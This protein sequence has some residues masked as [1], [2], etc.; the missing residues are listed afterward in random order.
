[1]FTRVI[2]QRLI[3]ELAALAALIALESMF[4]V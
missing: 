1:M 2:K 4:V 3:Y